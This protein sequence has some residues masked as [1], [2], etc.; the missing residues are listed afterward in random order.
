MRCTSCSKESCYVKKNPKFG[1]CPEEREAL[2]PEDLRFEKLMMAEEEKLEPYFSM[3]PN[4]ICDS[5]FL[6]IFLWS[7]SNKLEYC[8]IEGKAILWKMEMDGEPYTVMPS[9]REEDLPGYFKLTQ[10]Y[11][12]KVLNRPVKIFLADEE[13]V[14]LL[15]LRENPYYQISVQE[16]LKDYLYDAEKLRTL[17]GRAYHKKKNLV[18][19]FK[20]LYDGRWEYRSLTGKDGGAIRGFLENWYATAKSEEEGLD[21]EKDGIWEILRYPVAPGIRMGSIFIDGKM[22]AFTMGNYNELEE[23]AFICVEKA[24]AQIPGLYQMINQQFIVQEF[25]KSRVVNREDDVGLE[26]LRKAKLSYNPIG[27]AQKYTVIQNLY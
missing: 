25:P 2:K 9:C 15:K 12:N 4:Q 18:N 21:K 19:K 11:F 8:L 5:S 1:S 7:R 16:D 13:A 17:S 10:D 20:K 26:G 23:M 22:E 24:N 27:Y 6:D 3:R 14:E